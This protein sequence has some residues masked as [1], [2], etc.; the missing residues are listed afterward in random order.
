MSRIKLA[1]Q[2][3]KFL[4]HNGSNISRQIDV[5]EKPNG[6]FGLKAVQAI[7]CFDIVASIP[8]HLCITYSTQASPELEGFN[9][10]AHVGL[11][12]QLLTEKEE[13]K[14]THSQ[15][16]ALLPERVQNFPQFWS[17]DVWAHFKGSTVHHMFQS[18]QYS[19]Q[20]E[21]FKTL[22]EKSSHAADSSAL[23]WA[24]AVT[25]CCSLGINRS[26]AL[27]PFINFAGHDSRMCVEPVGSR[28]FMVLYGES[29]ANRGINSF[30]LVALSDYEAGTE[31]NHCFGDIT[32]EDKILTYGWL[33]LE[34]DVEDY[35][36]VNVLL[37]FAPAVRSYYKK[38][39]VHILCQFSMQAHRLG[40][41]VTSFLR[42]S[43]MSRRSLVNACRKRSRELQTLL[44]Q[45]ED[46]T[47]GD[48]SEVTH[49]AGSG[50]DLVPLG[51]QGREVDGGENCLYTSS[52]GEFRPQ[53]W[54]REALRRD[55]EVVD[56]LWS[57]L[58]ASS[59]T[60]KRK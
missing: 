26:L 40:P 16:I 17:K 3:Q 19:S 30:N 23:Q 37:P 27:V 21:A 41:S 47:S 59:A 22:Q 46:G 4:E 38:P 33:D 8:E 52:S 56:R 57:Y 11:G 25:S 5:F 34:A 45:T 48:D 50:R 31:I 10:D 24:H 14:S 58:D 2:L 53:Y 29:S 51:N 36:S 44:R 35:S 20:I 60:S 7:K 28:G 49:T 55:L 13:A 42:E 1:K 32:F 6:Q 18:H 9:A 39:S 12:C 15:H 54:A 43:G